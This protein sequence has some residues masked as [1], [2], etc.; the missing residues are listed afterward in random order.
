M[1][2]CAEYYKRCTEL[3]FVCGKGE[4]VFSAIMARMV[5]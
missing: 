5:H 3:S 1:L 4:D 2:E